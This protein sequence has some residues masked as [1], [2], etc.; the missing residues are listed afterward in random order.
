MN[1]LLASGML[2][3]WTVGTKQSKICSHIVTSSGTED[4]LTAINASD[5]DY[6]LESNVNGRQ[7][8]ASFPWAET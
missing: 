6:T 2:T 8:Y 4:T 5:R 1:A 3:H 7:Y